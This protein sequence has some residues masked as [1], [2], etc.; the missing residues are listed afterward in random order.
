MPGNHQTWILSETEGSVFLFNPMP[1]NQPWV[2][3]VKQGVVCSLLQMVLCTIFPLINAPGVCNFQGRHLLETPNTKNTPEN[4]PKHLTNQKA[5]TKTNKQN[6]TN[7]Q[8]K[9][10]NKHTKNL[11]TIF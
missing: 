2:Y 1:L 5:K 9:Q 11:F 7:K 8:T 10:T 3:I 4:I 6:K